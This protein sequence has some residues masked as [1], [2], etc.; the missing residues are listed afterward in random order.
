[1]EYTDSD[2]Q[3]AI[4]TLARVEDAVQAI[5]TLRTETKAGMRRIPRRTTRVLSQ[6][7]SRRAL[8][9]VGVG[10]VLGSALGGAGMAVARALF[11]KLLAGG[12]FAIP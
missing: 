8:V 3:R 4:D 5:E 10:L 6:A 12:Q 2:R 7:L 11:L 9:L 1:M